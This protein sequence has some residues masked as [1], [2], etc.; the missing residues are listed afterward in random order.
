MNADHHIAT[1]SADADVEL[2]CTVDVG[3]GYVLAEKN[4]QTRSM[5]IGTI[6]IDS[7]FSPV[8]QAST[9]R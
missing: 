8:S 1:L 7:I 9:T 6:P 2:E 3:K 4:K 5:P